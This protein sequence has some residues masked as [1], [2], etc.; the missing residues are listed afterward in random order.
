[1]NRNLA[2]QLALRIID[3]QG[4]DVRVIGSHSTLAWSSGG[5][6]NPTRE[7]TLKAT[8]YSRKTA[9]R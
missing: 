3:I 9:I 1:M 7:S 2:P 5:S 4:C 8:E 6:H